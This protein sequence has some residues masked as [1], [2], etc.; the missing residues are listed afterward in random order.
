MA[1][2]P[3]FQK[4]MFKDVEFSWPRLDQPY[5]YDQHKK[6]T[7][8]CPPTAQMAGYS[9]AWE[10]TTEQADKFKA[11]MEAHYNDCRTR[12]P[13]L[14]DFSGVFGMSE[15]EGTIRLNAKK[16]AMNNNGEENKAPSVIDVF[17]DELANKQIWSGSKGSVRILAYPSI[18]PQNQLG[19]ISLLL[20]AVQV[21]E[22]RYGGENFEDD[23]GKPQEKSGFADAGYGSDAGGRPGNDLDQE[24]PFGP[25]TRI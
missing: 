13:K 21:T 2:N 12:D 23:F 9:L 15:R 3:A 17:H 11:A 7:V 22:A 16:S 24:I 18:N 19:G 14:P 4:A 8:A 6:E 10:I 25:E 20:N 1:S 5:R